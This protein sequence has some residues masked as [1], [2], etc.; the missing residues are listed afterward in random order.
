MATKINSNELLNE[1]Q[2]TLTKCTNT[3]NDF[4]KLDANLL[5]QK[6]SKEAWSALECIEH[7][8]LYADF[9]IPKFI[10]IVNKATAGT[11][12]DTFS[13]GFLGGWA[14]KS[15]KVTN[16]KAITKM[17]TFKSKNPINSILTTATIDK[18]L[19]QQ[20]QLE[21]VLAKAAAI[22]L[23]KNRCATT[24]GFFISFKFGDILQFIIYHIERHIIQAKKATL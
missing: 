19:Q 17:K 4:L 14:A 12:V 2:A 16:G 10:D 13:S 5:N 11:A 18:F 21:L 20:Q 6:T 8:N 7:L 23:N 3:V 1:L 15:M 9:Y 22:N 24:L